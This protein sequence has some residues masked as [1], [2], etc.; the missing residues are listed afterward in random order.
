MKLHRKPVSSARVWKAQWVGLVLTLAQLGW[1]S[2]VA[3][4]QSATPPEARAGAESATPQAYC[5]GLAGSTAK[6]LSGLNH[7]Q[8]GLANMDRYYKKDPKYPPKFWLQEAVGDFSYVIGHNP[9][10]THPLMADVHM[11]RAHALT[12]SGQATAAWQDYVRTIQL[13]PNRPK[14]YLD[15]ARSYAANGLKAEALETATKGLRCLPSNKLLQQAYVKYGGKLPY[16]APVARVQK[17][18]PDAAGRAKLNE[19]PSPSRGNEGDLSRPDS[20]DNAASQ[21]T[22]SPNSAPPAESNSASA[23]EGQADSELKCR[24]CPPDEIQER[25]RESFQSGSGQ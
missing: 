16:P 21:T 15:L 1:F 3:S 24:F 5:V 6:G 20:A 11:Q 18:E 23:Q 8:Y 19:E 10:A 9:G 13:D 7:W 17:A 4:A 22:E 2:S 12:L 14:A 25:W